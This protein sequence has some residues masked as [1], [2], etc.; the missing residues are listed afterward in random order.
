MLGKKRKEVRQ[1]YNGINGTALVREKHGNGSM[2]TVLRKNWIWEKQEKL[3]TFLI[4]SNTFLKI[5]IK[6]LSVKCWSFW[7]E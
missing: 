7:I 5:I 6:D 3:I 4:I 2:G 1:E